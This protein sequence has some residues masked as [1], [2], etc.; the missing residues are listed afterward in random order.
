MKKYIKI[1]AIL[2]IFIIIGL[3]G[4]YSSGVTINV[5]IFWGMFLFFTIIA[6]LI[7]L[8]ATVFIKGSFK[9]RFFKILPFSYI[10]TGLVYI[11]G[12][13]TKTFVI[14]WV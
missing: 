8:C 2:L 10:V 1:F 5:H 12:Y 6:S 14:L 9:Q 3:L 13:F 11:L 7:T 4:S